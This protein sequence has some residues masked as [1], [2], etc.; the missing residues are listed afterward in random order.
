MV[1]W[2]WTTRSHL[3]VSPL[4]RST[5]CHFLGLPRNWEGLRALA[6]L[7]ASSGDL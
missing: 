7:L 6:L 4:L 5:A 3:A 2:P 1:C